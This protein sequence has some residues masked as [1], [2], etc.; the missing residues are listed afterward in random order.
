MK[1][2]SVG[3]ISLFGYKNQIVVLVTKRFE[4]GPIKSR[5]S[6]FPGVFSVASLSP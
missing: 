4:S 1:R 2:I 6:A 5:V 3:A